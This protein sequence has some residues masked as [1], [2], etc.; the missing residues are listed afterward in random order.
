[1]LQKDTGTE[2]NKILEVAH[3]EPGPL[4]LDYILLPYGIY[5]DKT[6]PFL[7]A[8]KGDRMRFYKGPLVEIKCVKLIPQDEIC[9]LLSRMRYGIS[10]DKVF[11]KWQSYARLEGHSSGILSTKECIFVVYGKDESKY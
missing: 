6:R 8:K 10:F 11:R 7:Q 3:S 9:E 2:K 5:Y 4:W 1:M